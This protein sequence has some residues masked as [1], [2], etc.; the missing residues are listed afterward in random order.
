MRPPLRTLASLQPLWYLQYG[1]VGQLA[2]ALVAREHVGFVQPRYRSQRRHSPSRQRHTV[3][4]LRFRTLGR[5]H[6]DFSLQIK[7]RLFGFDDLVGP[8]GG[9]NQKL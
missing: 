7:L 2:A 6:P 8:R 4:T 5:N 9:Q 1:R 3:P